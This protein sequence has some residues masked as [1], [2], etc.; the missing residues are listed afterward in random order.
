MT[1]HL[2]PNEEKDRNDVSPSLHYVKKTNNVSYKPKRKIETRDI[3]CKSKR[4]E[5]RNDVSPSLHYVKKTNNV[6]FKPK[7]KKR[8]E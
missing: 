2:N 1:C 6:S 3:P 8:N 4:R 7:R 5:D